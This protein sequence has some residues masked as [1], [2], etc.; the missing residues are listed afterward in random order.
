[1]L[2]TI[3]YNTD[4]RSEANSLKMEVINEW[5]DASVNMMGI[6]DAINNARYQVQLDG[7]VVY[8]GQTAV[9]NTT[10]INS[11]KDRL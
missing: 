1:M 9:D 6:R 11:I 4:F 10:V 5:S 7:A 3:I 2:V 8:S